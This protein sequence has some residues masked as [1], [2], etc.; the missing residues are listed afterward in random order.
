MAR[1]C[2]ARPRPG[3]WLSLLVVL[4]LVGAALPNGAT[5]EQRRRL[6]HRLPAHP[7]GAGRLAGPAAALWPHGAW[8]AARAGRLRPPLGPA[9]LAALLMLLGLRHHTLRI[10][11]HTGWLAAGVALTLLSN[12][13]LLVAPPLA[14]ALLAA[15]ALGAA[16]MAPAA[17]RRA[18]RRAGRPGAAR[19][20]L[21]RFAAVLRRLPAARGHRAG[22]CVWLLQLAGLAAERSGT[23]ICWC[24]GSW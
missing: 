15:L 19:A 13:A 10:A 24:R 17:R 3:A 5:G 18:A 9:A 23:A 21:D 4:A 22:E 8:M 20:A 6:D 16:L 7:S 14:C 11:P 2:R 1:Q 12:A